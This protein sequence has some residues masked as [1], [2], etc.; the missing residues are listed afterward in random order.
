[1]KRIPFISIVIPAYNAAKTIGNI[2]LSLET[3]NF[4]DF[5]LII[6]D[7]G[8][9]DETE[10][11][12]REYAQKYTNI[13]FFS[14]VNKGVSSARN[15]GFEKTSGDYVLFLDSDDKVS[16][17]LLTTVYAKAQSG[18]FRDD[19]IIFSKKNV[20]F[21]GKIVSINQVPEMKSTIID[22]SIF[23]TLLKNNLLP[24][25]YNKVVKKEFIKSIRFKNLSVG[26][27]FQFVLDIIQLKPLTAFINTVLYTYDLES[28][29]SIMQKYNSNRLQNF[30]MQKPQL[31]KIVASL[32]NSEAE[33]EQ[34]VD[35][36]NLDTLNR[37]ITN[38]FR[39]RGG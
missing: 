20:N 3:Q 6:I 10:S 2:I 22:A 29:D 15:A 30:I 34:V 37:V 31:E 17:H 16:S 7:D 35:A 33:R 36:I 32:A 4:N 13:N 1:M 24:T 14:Q 11:I 8:S 9:I 39:K 27:D 5:E 23:N 25:M 38:T 18:H 26:E 12:V 28:N 21:A 19:L